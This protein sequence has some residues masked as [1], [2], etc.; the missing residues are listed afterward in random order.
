MSWTSAEPAGVSVDVY[1][2]PSQL[3]ESLDEHVLRLRELVTEGVVDEFD[4]HC[5]PGRVP[6][7]SPATDAVDRFQ[8]FRSWARDND[9]SIQPPFSVHTVSS[10]F[11]GEHRTYL[12]TPV[13]C[14]AVTVGDALAG[15][16]P[17]TAG[18]EHRSIAD[19]IEELAAGELLDLDAFEDP[20]AGDVVTCAE[21]GGDL[22]NVQGLRICHDC[23]W[24]DSDHA[25]GRAPLVSR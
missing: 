8:E 23:A 15:V 11:T 13:C 14:L 1:V 6:T 12:S 16:Y 7:R 4:V 24:I 21:C 19:G 3:A 5:W 10:E 2:R 20:T 25:S 9:V 22:I 18:D 17:H